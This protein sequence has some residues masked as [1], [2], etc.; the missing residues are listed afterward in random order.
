MSLNRKL[1]AEFVGT[2]ILVFMGTG[3]ICISSTTHAFSHIGVA[4]VFGIVVMILI[5]SFGHISGAHFNPAVSIGFFINKDLSLYEMI[6][7][8]TVQI[9]GAIGASLTLVALFGDTNNLG[10]TKPAAQWSQSFVLELILT[11]ILMSVILMSAAHGKANKPFAGI[12]IGATVAIEALVFGP[13]C[14]ASMNPARSIGPA[15]ISRNFDFLWIY[16]VATILGAIIS[17][18]IYKVVFCE[19]EEDTVYIEVLNNVKN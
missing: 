18:L 15:I 4:V 8:C 3:A 17:V 14:G 7:Y 10:V 6:A 16:I 13:I 19:K 9:C 5:Y 2:F 11:F 1:I 12:A